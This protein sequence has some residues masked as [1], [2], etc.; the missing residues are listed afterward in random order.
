M[1]MRKKNKKINTLLLCS[2][3]FLFLAVGFSAFA[4]EL[5][6][7]PALGAETPQEFM[8]KIKDGTY[9]KED[10]MALYIKYA[11]HFIIMIAGFAAFYTLASGAVMYLFHTWTGN[12][13]GAGSALSTISAGF[14]GT[15]VILSS[16]LLVKTIDPKIL[17]SHLSLE[18]PEIDMPELKQVGEP[19]V[20]FAE[21]PMGDLMEEVLARAEV[22]KEQAQ[23]TYKIAKEVKEQSACMRHLSYK[24]GCEHLWVE[25]CECLEMSECEE[26]GNAHCEGDPCDVIGELC[27]GGQG[28][29]RQAINREKRRLDLLIEDLR[30]ERQNLIIVKDNLDR[31]NL[32]LKFAEGLI[33]DRQPL[34]PAGPTGIDQ[35]ELDGLIFREVAGSS[36]LFNYMGFVGEKQFQENQ[37]RLVKIEELWPYEEIA[38]ITMR[39]EGG[40]IVIFGCD[41]SCKSEYA[42]ADTITPCCILCKDTLVCY[43]NDY[44]SNE[45]D[46][47]TDDIFPSPS[48]SP[49]G[50]WSKNYLK[51]QGYNYAINFNGKSFPIP[52]SGI[53]YCGS[54]D[55]GC[56]YYK[57]QE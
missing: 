49:Q 14:L 4:I 2:W 34:G 13:G 44:R 16:Y 7:P 28:N 29:I 5:I 46:C 38:P 53:R 36:E 23:E 12:F 9:S 47:E 22:V 19:T 43:G 51:E 17:I 35:E 56:D 45:S 48:E 27:G 50:G 10:A 8:P 55:I 15:A 39:N 33:R 21:V 30:E 3:I 25:D 37:D 54:A 11:Y 24:C 1:K 42:D 57:C 41:S 26:C 6:Y 31:A 40:D 20:S 52:F 18:R 32:R